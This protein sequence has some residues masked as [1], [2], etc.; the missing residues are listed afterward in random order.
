M[1]LTIP[2]SAASFPSTDQPA[3]GLFPRVSEC[4]VA[5]AARFLDGSEGLVNELLDDGVITFRLENG[6]R[7][8]Q[9]NSLLEFEQK[10]D[11]QY[12]GLEEIVR[13]SEEMGL[14]DD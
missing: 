1:S 11:R 12:A 6:E 5:Q 8:V 4:T 9:W 10:E 7:L 14:Y 13:L 2:P 3:L